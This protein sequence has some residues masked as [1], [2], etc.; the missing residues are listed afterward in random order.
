MKNVTLEKSVKTEFLR[1]HFKNVESDDLSEVINSYPESV[2]YDLLSIEGN[3]IRYVENPTEKLQL[4][5]V[6][7]NGLNI[8]YISD[9]SEKVKLIAI[10]ENADSI[11]FIKNPSEK[12]QILAVKLR[13]SA[14]RYIN[15]PSYKAITIVN[16]S[17][18]NIKRISFSRMDLN[19]LI[20][21][22]K[23][24]MN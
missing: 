6:M 11:K 16:K 20:D 19:K 3:L 22:S 23:V 24:S 9:P 17:A 14:L 8:R 1:T 7:H 15:N 4:I 12:L 10:K 2:V 21:N 13:P 5:S 18:M